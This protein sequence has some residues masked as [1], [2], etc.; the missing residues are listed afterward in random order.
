MS[1]TMIENY[2]SLLLLFIYINY[3]CVCMSVCIYIV[4]FPFFSLDEH[5]YLKIYKK[6]EKKREKNEYKKQK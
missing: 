1:I 2:V 3:K 6:L 5:N 4:F